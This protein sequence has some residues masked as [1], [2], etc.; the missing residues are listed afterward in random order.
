MHVVMG[1]ARDDG[2]AQAC[3]SIR[4]NVMMRDVWFCETVDGASVQARGLVGSDVMERWTE[5][6]R[7]VAGTGCGGTSKKAQ[8]S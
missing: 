1:R 5:P 7:T 4:S 8:E 6:C 2:G 3:I